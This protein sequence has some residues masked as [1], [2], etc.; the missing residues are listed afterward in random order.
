M[1]NILISIVLFSILFINSVS[2]QKAYH[3]RPSSSKVNC[4][5]SLDSKLYAGTSRGVFLSLDNGN[6]WKPVNNGLQ[7]GDSI[8]NVTH[9]FPI[10]SKLFAATFTNGIFYSP[11]DDDLSWVSANVQEDSTNSL[12][13]LDLSGNDNNLFSIIKVEEPR[14]IGSSNIYDKLYVSKDNGTSW[15]LSSLQDKYVIC[16]FVNDNIVFAGT[17]SRGIY[18]SLDNGLTWTESNDGLPIGTAYAPTVNGFASNGNVVFSAVGTD[19][20][21]SSDNGASWKSAGLAEYT[22]S[23]TDKSFS[24]KFDYFQMDKAW[25]IFTYHNYLFAN[26]FGL[27]VSKDNGLS[28]SQCNNVRAN[29]YILLSALCRQPFFEFIRG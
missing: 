13:I 11:I 24:D 25:P 9:L 26:S 19:V 21:S 6:S 23:R 5:A 12:C 16:L 14:V 20:F 7:N 28:W 4:F 8:Y 2:G 1:N 29:L 22:K 18:R 15:N 17:S 27:V 10:N 3:Y